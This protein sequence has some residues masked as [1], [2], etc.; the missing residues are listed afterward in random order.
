MTAP[1]KKNTPA[2]KIDQ[3]L[4]KDIK[5]NDMRLGAAMK[6]VTLIVNVASECGL[7]N[8][9][10]TQLQQVYTRQ[11][12][13][14]NFEILAF[15]CNQFAKNEPRCAM[16]VKHDMTNKFQATFVFM[17]KVNVNGPEADPLFLL[18]NKLTTF[19]KKHATQ[20]LL[21]ILHF[22]QIRIL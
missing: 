22:V 12:E 6:R 1:T 11:K 5:G 10:Y 20:H 4:V 2:M 13:T 21:P 18:A 8:T 15:P 3:F 17:E 16:D 9:N 14:G 7:S 19:H